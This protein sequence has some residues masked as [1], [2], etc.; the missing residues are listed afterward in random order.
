MDLIIVESP[1]KTKTIG[2]FLGQGYKVKASMGHIRDLPKK[3]IGIDLDNG[4]VPK[5]VMATEKNKRENVKRLKDDAAQANIVYLCTD[6]DREGEAIAWH[7]VEALKIPKSKIKRATF[8][9]ITQKAVTEALQNTRDI[10]MDLVNAQQARRLLDRIVGYKLSPFLWRKLPYKGLSA[11]RV[12]SAALKL[13]VDREKAILAFVPEEYWRITAMMVKQKDD[14]TEFKSV[15]T[16]VMN[17]EKKNKI[18]IKNK[19]DADIILS[20]LKS[21]IFVIENIIKKESIKKA[22]VPFTTST[23]QMEAARKLGMAA[24]KTMK[25]AQQ[26]YEGIDLNGQHKGLITYMRTDSLNLSDDA[27]LEIRDTIEKEYGKQYLTEEPVKYKT[28]SKGAQ[29]AHEAIRPASQKLKPEDLKGQIDD[30]LLKLYD[31]IWKRTAACQMTPAVFDTTTVEISSNKKYIFVSKGAIMKFKGFLLAYEEGTDE[32]EEDDNTLLPDLSVKEPLDC[33]EILPEQKFTQPPSRFTEATLVKELEKSGVGRPS[34]YA[35]ILNT[36]KQRGYVQI[37]KKRF[38]PTE[39]GIAVIDLLDKTF[40]DITDISFTAK[41]EDR[42]DEVAEGNMNWV[43]MLTDFYNPFKDNL[44]AQNKSIPNEQREPENPVACPQCGKKMVIKRSKIGEFLGC[45]DYPN[46]KQILNMDGSK[47]EYSK[48][49]VKLHATKKCPQCGSPLAERKGKYGLFYGCSD[50]PKC[51]YIEP[52]EKKQ[53]ATKNI[54]MKC[55][56]CNNG[57]ILE[58]KTKKGTIFWGC[59]Q[60]PQCDYASWDNPKK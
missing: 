47:V 40:P 34:T 20:E 9:E 48:K 26:L 54:G 1:A 59:N 8:S 12:Q 15:L 3:E 21:S 28:K 33:K 30:D 10:N 44:Q 55:P 32:K 27:L 5:Y 57:D 2:S 35:T 6:L 14:F 17:G 22:P 39:V 53:D 37:E 31:L 60:Y 19:N 45:S 18:E 56:K 25:I 36:I 51:K 13:I 24:E 43:S 4:F 49:E 7:L 42:L 29:E 50:Y 23:L 52:S 38:V 46:C 58:K 41:I 16:Y 11:G